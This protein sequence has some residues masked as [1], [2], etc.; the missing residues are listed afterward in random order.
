[1]VVVQGIGFVGSAVAAAV[2]AAKD[3]NGSPRYGVVGIDLPSARARIDALNRGEFP[4]QSSDASLA[5][6]TREA[7]LSEGNLAATDSPEPYSVADVI[8]MDVNLDFDK[9]LGTVRMEGFKVALGE[10]ARRMKPECLLV[11]ESTVPPGTCE[12]V[13]EPALRAAF[14]RRGIPGRPFVAH[15]YERVMPGPKYLES[16][17]SFWR[18]VAANDPQSL[19]RAKA[20]FESFVEVRE[21][22]LQSLASTTASETAKVLENSYR[23]A[24][25]AFIH[26]WTL[27]AEKSGID[28]FAVVRSIRVRKGTHD[29]MMLPGFGVGGYCLTKDGLLAQWGADHLLNA[30]V[31]LDAT[32]SAITLNDRMPLHA[33]DLLKQGLGGLKGKKILVL[34]LSYLEGVADVR[35]SPTAVLFSALK[36]GGAKTLVHDPLVKDPEGAIPRDA[37]KPDL[38][39]LGRFDAVVLA[40]RHREYLELST[41]C[42]A[43]HLKPGALVLDAFDL[44]NDDKIKA[45]LF[46]GFKVIGIG[47]G[48][49]Q[50]LVEGA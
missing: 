42:L 10:I 47:K 26:E 29:N 43:E 20:F 23:A 40:V 5:V 48:H 6:V 49:I 35:C 1:M 46:R 50:K 17:R 14:K 36:G 28:L 13:V 30:G 11:V 34:G 45:L 4:F 41:A 22:P 25:I 31:S 39:A 2:A 16:V 21:F 15:A 44:M 7:V 37:F 32:L 19:A 12:R 38:D 9:K 27:L 18:T 24:N 3:E 33:R 8:L